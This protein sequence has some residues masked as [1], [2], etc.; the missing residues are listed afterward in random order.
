MRARGLAPSCFAPSSEARISVS[1]AGFLHGAS[2]FTTMLARNGAV[3]RFEVHLRRLMDTARLFDLRIDAT[4]ESL[5]V[6]VAEV[7]SA[8]GQPQ[9]LT[10]GDA[11]RRIGRVQV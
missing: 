7:L 5:R 10:D 4:P 1:D 2:V 9:R 3:F 6:G 11:A 8:N